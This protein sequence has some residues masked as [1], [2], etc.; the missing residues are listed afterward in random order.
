MWF[1]WEYHVETFA[2]VPIEDALTKL[3]MQGWK[4]VSSYIALVDA[5]ENRDGE[6]KRSTQEVTLIFIR[7][8]GMMGV[9]T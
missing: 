7:P 5:Y 6:Q 4:L 8:K 3:G 9:P 2:T 1:L